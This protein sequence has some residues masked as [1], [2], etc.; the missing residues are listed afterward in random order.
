MSMVNAAIERI[1]L[2]CSLVVVVCCLM[3]VVLLLYVV[4]VV[5]VLVLGASVLWRVRP[6]VIGLVSS[7]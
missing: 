5:V 4:C 1:N 7:W 3:V 2:E 6:S